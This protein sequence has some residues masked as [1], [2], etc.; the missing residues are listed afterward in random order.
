MLR[1]FAFLGL[2]LLTAA[3]TSAQFLQRAPVEDKNELSIGFRFTMPIDVSIGNVGVYNPNV[4]LLDNDGNITQYVF[5]DGDVIPYDRANVDTSTNFSYFSA[6]QLSDSNVLT[7]NSY[8]AE[9]LNQVVGG[10]SGLT[11]GWELQYTRY[12]GKKNNF[13]VQAGF[14]SS[15]FESSQAGSFETQLFRTSFD[16]A[17]TNPPIEGNTNPDEPF[18]NGGNRPILINDPDNIPPTISDNPLSDPN[19]EISEIVT[20]EGMWDLKSA[21]YNFR[22]GPIYNLTVLDNLDMSFGLGVAATYFSTELFSL[23]VIPLP[24]GE[25]G[26]PSTSANLHNDEEFLLGGYA[27]ATAV[28]R[29]TERLSMFG[30]VQYQATAN[31]FSTV[32]DDG[33]SLDVDVQS[34]IHV[35]AGFGIKF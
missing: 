32:D 15:Q 23:E 2:T 34:N 29:F 26:T 28:Y 9:S 30:G 13:G 8:S 18:F 35:R 14:T 33:R 20:G 7:Y 5:N 11:T 24:E 25:E 16:F 1:L 17:V 19:T 27:D 6:D 21:S 4:T 12:I 10:D 22:V 31:D 3:S